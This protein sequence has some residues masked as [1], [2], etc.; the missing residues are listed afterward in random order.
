MGVISTPSGLVPPLVVSL[1][2]FLGTNLNVCLLFLICK[3]WTALIGPRFAAASCN[4][5]PIN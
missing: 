2:V 1:V 5:G 3:S 4:D